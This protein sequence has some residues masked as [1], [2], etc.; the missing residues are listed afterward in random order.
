MFLDLIF[1]VLLYSMLQLLNKGVDLN[2]SC[3]QNYLSLI[4]VKRYAPFFFC[5]QNYLSLIQVK[6]YAPFFFVA[7]FL[8]KYDAVNTLFN[9]KYIML[10]S[11]LIAVITELLNC[12]HNGALE[13][14]NFNIHA[15]G[16]WLPWIYIVLS[17][18]IIMKLEVLDNK[19]T[20]LLSF[21]GAH[22]LDVYVLH[23]FIVRSISM[24]FLCSYFDNYNYLILELLIISPISILIAVISVYIGRVIRANKR[25]ESFIFFR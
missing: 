1:I 16:Y 14:F 12:C 18:S 15:I 24:A 25:I 7:I 8:R 22:T 11:L 4:Q 17:I 3:W 20:Q 13:M 5:W 9:N 10:A 21:I 2:S 23:F 6:R 19:M